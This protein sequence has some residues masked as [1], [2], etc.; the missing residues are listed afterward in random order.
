MVRTV[1][2][3]KVLRHLEHETVAVILGLQRIQDFR[4]LVGELHVHDRTD[5]LGDASDFVG[6]CL[7]RHSVLVPN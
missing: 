5:D 4:Q 3:P 7:R 2:S 1:D 6:A